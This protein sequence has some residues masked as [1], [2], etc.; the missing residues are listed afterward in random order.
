MRAQTSKHGYSSD[1]GGS[2]RGEDRTARVSVHLG[3][4]ARSD[5]TAYRR[6][7]RV[8]WCRVKRRR[9]SSVG[10]PRLTSRSRGEGLPLR[11]RGENETADDAHD[12]DDEKNCDSRTVSRP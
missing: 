4:I 8:R 5:A 2:R 11:A 10:L 6:G 9:T 7:A 1:D 3:V 12:T